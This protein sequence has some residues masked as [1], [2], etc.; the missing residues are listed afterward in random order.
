MNT[1]FSV[2]NEATAV[3]Y[4]YCKCVYYERFPSTEMME[5]SIILL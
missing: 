4:K 1:I 2:D 5:P 3:D